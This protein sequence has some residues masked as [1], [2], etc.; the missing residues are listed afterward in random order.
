MTREISSQVNGLIMCGGQGSRLD[1]DVEKPLFEVDGVPMIDRVIEALDASEIS[2][3]YA[4]VSPQSPQTRAHVADR[5]VEVIETP[6]DGYLT[7]ALTAIER[8]GEPVLTTPSD[9]P[10]LDGQLFNDL[11]RA[12]DGRSLGCYTPVTLNEEL[13]MNVNHP[14][15]CGECTGAATGLDITA[16]PL[17]TDRDRLRT[18]NID[19]EVKYCSYSARPATNVNTLEH[20][21]VA[22]RLLA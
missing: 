12:Y 20:A 10:L 5:Q 16:D 22:E 3:V 9:S 14:T 15:D 6:G 21:A 4:A 17:P 2:T 13:G 18:D 7:D 19:P 1:S 11:L 8:I